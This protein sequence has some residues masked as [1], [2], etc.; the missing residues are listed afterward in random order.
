M[1]DIDRINRDDS[2]EGRRKILLFGYFE[3][4][5]TDKEAKTFKRS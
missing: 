1:L 3:Q 2:I 4:P 5:L